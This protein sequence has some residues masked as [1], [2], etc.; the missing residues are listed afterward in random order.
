MR[1]TYGK[2]SEMGPIGLIFARVYDRLRKRSYRE[3]PT[4]PVKQFYYDRGWKDAMTM[5]ASELEEEFVVED[6]L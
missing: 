5:L 6:L 3:G 1:Y 2:R 4:T